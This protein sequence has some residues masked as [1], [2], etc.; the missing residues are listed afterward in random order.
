VQADISDKAAGERLL[1]AT[2]VGV[3]PPRLAEPA[4]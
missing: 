4:A 2:R 3:P 1:A